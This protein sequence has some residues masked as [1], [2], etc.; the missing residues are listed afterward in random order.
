[1]AIKIIL[2]YILPFFITINCVAQTWK[3]VGPIN[4]PVNQSG[5]INGLGRVTQLKFHPTLANVL[6]ATSASG[7]AYKSI[8][9]GHHWTLLNTDN[10]PTINLACIAIDPNNDQILYLGS[11]DPNYYSNDL[12]VYKSINGGQNWNLSTT[13]LGTLLTVD[14][15][16]NPSNTQHLIAAAKSGIWQ[17][18]DGA[19]TWTNVKVGGAFRD[20]KRQPNSNTLFAVTESQVWMSYNFGTT[21]VQNTSTTFNQTSTDGMR[22]IVNP[23]DTN[24][25]Y[26]IS[27][28]NNG[29]VFKSTNGGTTFTNIYNSNTQCLFCYDADPIN[30]GQGN[31][32]MAACG[33][34]SDAN[35][36]YVA[37]HCLWES[38]NGGITWQQKTSWPDEL[39]TDH[40]QFV[41]NPYNNTKLY[42]VNDGGVWQRQGLLDSFWNPLCDGIT[43]M[44]IYKA[45][46]SNITRNQMSAGTQDNGE[47]Y[48]NNNGCYTNRGGDWGSRMEYDYST[49]DYVYYLEDGERRGFNP[50][51]SS[52]SYNSP[53]A[54]TNNSRIAFSNQNKELA[55]LAK[56]SMY[57]CTNLS[58]SN[59][60]WTNINPTITLC[61]DIAISKA[62][63]NLAFS[64]QN[65]KLFRFENLTTSPIVTS[66]TP[67]SSASVQGSVTTIPAADSIVYLSCGSRMYRS[68]NKGNTWVNISYNLPT[69]NIIK[70]YHDDYST[71]ETIYICSGN[72]VFTKAKA[73]TVW[74]N[75]S[76][77][78]P[79]IANI[80]SF[81][82][83][84]DSTIA[85]K[86]KVAYY[87]RGIWEYL[88]HPTYKPST[89]FTADNT[90]VCIGNT[91]HF[92]DQ[93]AEN[94][95]A[96]SWSFAGGTPS[97]STQKN[98]VVTY[99]IA[100]NYAVTLIATNAN[101]S[102]TKT[103]ANYITVLA[104]KPAVDKTPMQ[105]ALLNGNVNSSGNAGPLNL[106]NNNVTLMCWVKPNG[107]QDDFAGLLFTR[108]ANATS[109]LSIKDN[110]E[111]R[112]HWND[113]NYWF[114]PGLFVKPNE[115]NHCALVVTP[116][117][118]TIYLNGVAAKNNA[119]H[120]AS[121]FDGD[122]Y[123]G[124]DPTGNRVF[125]GQMDEA[126]VY[127]RALTQNEIREQMHLTK[128]NNIPADALVG[129]W[130]MNEI[131][132]NKTILNKA[133]CDN[134][135]KVGNALTL[136]KSNAPFGFGTSMR[137][138]VTTGGQ[139]NFSIADISIT[140][141][142]TGTYA[143]GEVCA[144]HIANSPD[145]MPNNGNGADD[146]YILDNYG[147]NA[148][149]SNCV[150]MQM[151]NCGTVNGTANQFQ[152]YKRGS[153]DFGNS[154]VNTNTAASTIVTGA[155][156]SFDFKPI[157][158]VTS[159]GQFVVNGPYYPTAIN[160]QT[161]VDFT[162]Y[163]NP[164]KDVIIVEKSNTYNAVINIVNAQGQL[165]YSKN[166]DAAQLKINCSN[167]SN[168]IYFYSII[169]NNKSI[170]GKVEILK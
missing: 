140:L 152:L 117:S 151:S 40:H 17:S 12:G 43:A 119:I 24:I 92:T 132:S 109:G 81:M 46:A 15:L 36:I 123:V 23:S 6:Y 160:P 59:P 67:P 126:V 96:Y 63:T 83:Y 168:G 143:N 165:V 154:W 103:T 41:F 76:G 61:K 26:V 142:T 18:L 134:Q 144:S 163:P 48:Y 110:N 8:D 156:G 155:N 21:W 42:S 16:I 57:I 131:T 166:I 29:V 68:S 74:Q 87:G 164:A 47:V 94:I 37:A 66:F 153:Y 95:T 31:Y 91:I 136:V 121:A 3:E 58:S 50:N 64:I 80:N 114:S 27:N 111:L 170:Q 148:I 52:T 149:F 71:N 89:D 85:S 130:Q 22:I 116:T 146:Y 90:L 13:G 161:I 107:V 49:D 104:D 60:T 100:G 30:T 112:Y 102:A 65:S 9:T 44:E 4:F 35:H 53:I 169:S 118:A 72:T 125:N 28:G 98:P 75:I 14:I 84:N 124:E 82:L 62:N 32:D 101:G 70:I 122:F 158:N 115:W 77:N 127:N 113:Q 133:K 128:N 141:P 167:W 11:G 38:V 51:L 73:D 162:V 129:Y 88:L 106:N 97:T 79:K 55:L 139:V 5:Q 56:D 147:S 78:L 10:L 25:V 120:P 7:G 108:S 34:P 54:P 150:D 19:A 45:A 138:P 1:M 99:N 137:L 69:T 157:S 20:I 145:V 39:H 105:A 86:I 159:F 135:L 2:Q 93:S 33:D